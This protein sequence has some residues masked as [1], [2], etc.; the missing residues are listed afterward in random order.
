MLRLYKHVSIHTSVNIL[1]KELS[2][3]YLQ[4][5]YLVVGL[6]KGKCKNYVR[7]KIKKLM[8]NQR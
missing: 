5:R 3:L 4:K 1:N 6:S 7:K 8:R 2:L